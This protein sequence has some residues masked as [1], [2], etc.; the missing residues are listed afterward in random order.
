MAK[1]TITNISYKDMG[2]LS[3]DKPAEALKQ[4]M[5]FKELLKEAA[6]E[7]VVEIQISMYACLK[8]LIEM[9]VD[10]FNLL[11]EDIK[12]SLSTLPI[13]TGLTLKVSRKLSNGEYKPYSCTCS[14]TLDSSVEIDKDWL[15]SQGFKNQTEYGRHLDSLNEPLPYGLT[16]EVMYKFKPDKWDNTHPIGKLV[17]TNKVSLTFKE[18]K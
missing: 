11:D 17:T 4:L 10:D 16:K 15:I 3:F 8:T 7:Q 6:P 2:G 9:L 18:D 5:R 13:D 12:N 1:K 14:N